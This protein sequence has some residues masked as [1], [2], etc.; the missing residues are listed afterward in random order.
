MTRLE[1]G[2]TLNEGLCLRCARELGIGPVND[3][4]AK[5]G[6]TDDELARMDDDMEQFA[7]MMSGGDPEEDGDEAALLPDGY[8]GQDEDGAES[9]E[10]RAPAV[11]FGSMLGD[12]FGRSMNRGGDRDAEKS[13]DGEK[14][15]ESGRSRKEKKKKA[16]FLDSYCV[17]LTARARDGALDRVIGRDRELARLVQILCRR[18]K[19][20]PCLIGEPGVGKTAIAEALAQ[21]I[22]AGEVP[23][24]LQ[25]KEVHLLDLTA[26]VAGTQFRGQFESRMK[27]LIEDIKTAGN[28]I[29]VI[30]EVHTIAGAGDAEGSMN[31]ANILKPALS[32]GEI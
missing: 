17:N 9:E 27:G 25:N 20:N 8:E 22:A 21:N 13:A 6:I 26:L 3:M 7:A 14:N 2:E 5:M 11:D 4:L 28:I 16:K 31:A 19:N 23:Y 12:L 24:K 1:N 18:Q 29:L 32:R 30:D 10:G 15:A